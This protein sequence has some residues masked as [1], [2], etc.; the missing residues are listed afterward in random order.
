MTIERIKVKRRCARLDLS[1][2]EG[3]MDGAIA[4]IRQAFKHSAEDNPDAIDFRFNYDY[5]DD[6]IEV[7]CFADETDA[8]YDAR[9]N[10]EKNR[11]KAVEQNYLRLKAQFEP[12]T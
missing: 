7:V 5:G 8:E 4:I 9:I 6:Y 1:D 11:F 10:A 12:N 3:T 2:F